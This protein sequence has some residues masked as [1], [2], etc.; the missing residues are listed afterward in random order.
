MNKK[1]LLASEED[2]LAGNAV[3]AFA[4][5]L[6]MVQ[7][8]KLPEDGTEISLIITKLTIPTP[9]EPVYLVS[10]MLLFTLSLVLAV[11]SLSTRLRCHAMRFASTISI[12]LAPIALCAFTVGWLE[13]MAVLASDQWWFLFLFYGGYAFFLF[14]GYRFVRGSRPS[15]PPTEDGSE[16]A[17][18]E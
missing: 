15:L 11:A 7:S 6:L 1:R 8:R 13:A 17:G 12:I 3:V 18:N 4:G 2:W 16:G 14:V 5:A 10:G 9:P